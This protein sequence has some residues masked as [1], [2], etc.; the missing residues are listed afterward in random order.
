MAVNE[1]SPGNHALLTKPAKRSGEP[2]GTEAL[3][4]RVLSEVGRVASRLAGE[5]HG[6]KWRAS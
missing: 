4:E 1:K 3:S 6:G 2:I 5:I